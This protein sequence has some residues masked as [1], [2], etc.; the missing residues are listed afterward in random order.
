MARGAASWWV[1]YGF[2]IFFLPIL[3]GPF[4]DRYGFK[5]S[6][7]ACF[8]IFAIGYFAVG[9]AALPWGRAWWRRSA[10]RPM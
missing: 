10:P 7:V 1:I 4:V 9:L 2:A 8:S 6:L 3:A 5:R